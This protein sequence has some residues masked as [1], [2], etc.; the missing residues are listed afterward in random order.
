MSNEGVSF[1][2]ILHSDA[3]EQLS[4][5]ITPVEKAA[6][7][8]QAYNAELLEDSSGLRRELIAAKGR[9]LDDLL[10]LS[11]SIKTDI[12]EADQK[13]IAS[14]VENKLGIVDGQLDYH[15]LDSR[16]EQTISQCVESNNYAIT[17]KIEEFTQKINIQEG[18]LKDALKGGAGKLG[19][20]KL[21]NQHI[22][23]ARNF[24]A[25][26]F[27]WARKIKFKP[28]GAGKLAGKI[29]K[30]AGIA[31]AILGAGVDLYDYFKEKKETKKLLEFKNSLKSDISEKFKDLFVILNSDDLY[32]QEFA[33]SYLE[34][35]KAVEQRNTELAVLQSQ[36]QKLR[37]YNEQISDWLLNGQKKLNQ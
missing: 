25:K 21:N 24:L 16:I 6:Q 35:C 10:T 9:L 2:R 3:R 26:Y 18:I 23:N 13:S 34:L 37:Q 7:N 19:K 30:G 4:T 11:S 20:V 33:P 29:S 8:A 17:T 15:I 22:L 14:L 1:M 12:D 27:E 31:G 36:I 32:F 5:I 28:H